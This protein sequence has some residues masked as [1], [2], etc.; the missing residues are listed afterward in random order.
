M[1]IVVPPYAKKNHIKMITSGRGART[2]TTRSHA[3][4]TYWMLPLKEAI[5]SAFSAAQIKGANT[6]RMAAITPGTRKSIAPNAIPII[7]KNMSVTYDRSLD[8]AVDNASPILASLFVMANIRTA[9]AYSEIKRQA[10]MAL[11][12]IR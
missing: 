3:F 5:G 12:F 4:L 7:I 6:N 1:S 8:N 9:W 11:L 10:A 2:N